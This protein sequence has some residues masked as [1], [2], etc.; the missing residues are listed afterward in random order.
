[1]AQW[2]GEPSGPKP[3]IG[4]ARMYASSASLAQ[5]WRTLLTWVSA[6]S[7]VDL[8]VI[9]H[10]YP[11]PLD[12][13][14]ARDDMGC[15]FMCGYPW[16]LRRDR[17]R[18]LAAPVP[19]PARYGNEPIYFTDFVVRA[20]S[21]FSILEDTFRRRLAYSIENSHSGYNAARHHLLAY[22]TGARRTLYAET[23]GPLVS[24]R[25]VLDAVIDGRADIGPVDSY[26][27]DLW[28][29]HLPE[30]VAAVRVIATTEPAPSPPLV[31]SPMIADSQ[32]A[33]LTAALL[34]AH[35]DA[36]LASTLAAL[37]LARF[38]EATPARFDV[39]LDRQRAA[40]SAGYPLLA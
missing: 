20:D 14:W 12:E 9:E 40:E 11:A 6:T 36:A 1:V 24:Q 34:E 7:G 3:L 39:F 33:R 23:V 16:A 37:Q 31:A 2:S 13:L 5:A 26:L 32:C 15:V 30:V 18:L 25:R 10:A 27:L 17:P 22:R 28:R 29:A 38:V 21:P 19:S 35:H 4:C 8:E